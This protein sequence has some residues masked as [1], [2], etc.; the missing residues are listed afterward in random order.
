MSSELETLE[1]QAVQLARTGVF[2]AETIRINRAIIAL[3]PHQESAWTRLGRAYLEQEQFDDAVEALRTALALSPSNRIATSLL[4]EVRRRRAM[5][6]ASTSRL[7]T[8]FGPRE[9]TILETLPAPDACQTLQP[10][11]SALLDTVNTTSIARR[12]V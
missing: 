7:S 3:A 10:R 2:G 9:F 6:P 5:K 11:I 12:I 8:G 4:T 1:R